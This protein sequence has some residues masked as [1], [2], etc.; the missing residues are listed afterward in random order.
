MDLATSADSVAAFA[1]EVFDPTGWEVREVR[2]RGMRLD[3]PDSYWALFSVD[4]YKDGEERDLRVVCKGAL[5]PD[6]WETLSA[7]LVR[8]GAGRPCDPIHSLGYPRLYQDTHHAYW[9]YPYDPAMPNL[10]AATDPL[11][12]AG[13]LIG[14]ES[15]DAVLHASR[16]IEV[17][18]VRYLPEIAAILRYTLD[19][20]GA[21]SKIF[22]KVQPGNRGYRTFN[23]VSGLWRAAAKYPGFLTLPRPLGFIQELGLLLEEAVKGKPVG[24][25]RLSTEFAMTGNAAAEALAVIHESGLECDVRIELERE[26]ARLDRVAEQFTYVLPGGHFLLRDLIGHMRDRIRKTS[27][28]EWRPTHGDM[29]YDQFIYHNETFTLLDFDY[30]ALAENSYDLGKFC[31]YLVPSN[32]ADW[33]ESAAAEEIRLVFIRRYMELR[34]HATLQRFQ[35]YEALQLALRAMAFMWAQQRGWERIAETFLVLAFER[36]K[37]RLPD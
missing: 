23:V 37:S 35:V 11:L 14:V 12:M 7:H 3:P 1:Q 33:R 19:L 22:G 34:P 10:H 31:A 8:N 18:R 36:L 2:R 32:P 16:R 21:P 30:F 20:P 29:K 6:A 28:E 9:F 24:N 17:E 15:P 5:N 27:E 13:V 4:I 25:N 26:I